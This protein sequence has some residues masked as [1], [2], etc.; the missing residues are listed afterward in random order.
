MMWL[1]LEV[2]VKWSFAS[3]VVW[4]AYYTFRHQDKM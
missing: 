1:I 4:A 2:A 3:V